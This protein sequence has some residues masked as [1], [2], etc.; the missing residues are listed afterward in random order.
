MNNISRASAERDLV[1]V[2]ASACRAGQRAFLWGAG[3][4]GAFVAA[5]VGKAELRVGALGFWGQG[6]AWRPAEVLFTG[7]PFDTSATAGGDEDRA[8][9]RAPATES[10]G[11]PDPV[12]IDAVER[13]VDEIRA[14]RCAKVVL[15]R[16]TWRRAPRGAVWDAAATWT[17]L[18][19]ANP[20]A[21]T[22]A[23]TD[24][25]GSVFVGASPELLAARHGPW[26]RTEALAGTAPRSVP[27]EALLQSAKDLAEHAV[28]VR[29][30]AAG[31]LGLSEPGSIEVPEGPSVRGLPRL[32]HLNTPIRA[33]L[34]PGVSLLDAVGALHPTPA[35]CGA[36][37]EA[38]A[39]FL[40]AREGFERGLYA[41][42]VGWVS[43]DGDGLFAVGIRSASLARDT[44]TLYAGAGIVAGSS[45]EAEWA[46][47]ELKLATVGEVLRWT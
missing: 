5:G 10:P 7:Q 8:P 18:R 15:A 41:G 11:R 19:A 9:L 38:A 12:W 21:W 23:V 44:A 36:P 1:E 47:T 3:Q 45:P 46:E 25:G 17:A 32:W 42:P 31:L 4:A 2:L 13:A 43:D 37:R 34:R 26:L 22:F 6:S 27:R 35:V 29:V 28:V 39:A 24:G 16:G 14:G 33:R 20:R 30:V 40:R